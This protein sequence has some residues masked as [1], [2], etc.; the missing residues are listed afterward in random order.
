M[1][2]RESEWALERAVMQIRAGAAWK[3]QRTPGPLASQLRA[4]LAIC[5]RTSPL[6]CPLSPPATVC[7]AVE[8]FKVQIVS[9]RSY[10]LSSKLRLYF[11][12]RAADWQLLS[13]L[14]QAALKV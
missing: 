3:W 9:S 6:I 4:L 1:L 13:S 14:V 2:R 10:D 11:K 8:K 5:T 7:R 12:I